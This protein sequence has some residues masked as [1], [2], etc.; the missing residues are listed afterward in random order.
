MSASSRSPL[1]LPPASRAAVEPLEEARRSPPRP[2]VPPVSPRQRVRIRPDER[3]AVVD[4]DEPVLARAARA[5]HEQRLDVG[6]SSREHRVRRLQLASTPRARAATRSRPSGSGSSATHA[7]GRGAAEEERHVDRDPQLVPG[8]VVELEAV[9]PQPAVGD[10]P[11]VAAAGRVAVEQQRCT[12]GR[13]TAARASPGRAGGGARRRSARCTGRSAP[14]TPTR[15][16]RGAARQAAEP[17]AGER[18]APV[19]RSGAPPASATF[20][21]PAV[22]DQQRDRVEV[23]VGSST[24]AAGA[25]HVVARARSRGSAARAPLSSRRLER[26]ARRPGSPA[27]RRRASPSSRTNSTGS[28]ATAFTSSAAVAQLAAAPPT[29]AQLAGRA[30]A[31]RRCER[32]TSWSRRRG[33]RRRRGA[34]PRPRSPRRRARPCG[35]RP[36][37][38]AS[39][40]SPRRGSRCSCPPS[41]GARRRP[42]SPSSST[43]PPWDS[44]YGR[45]SRAPRAPAPR[46]ARG[47]GRAAAAGATTSS[48]SSAASAPSCVAATC[49]HDPREPLAVEVEQRL[50][51]ARS[52]CRA[53]PGR[54]APRPPR[55]APRP[56]RPA[57]VPRCRPCRA[58]A[59][60]APNIGECTCFSVLPLP[61]YMCTPHGRHGSKLR[62]ARMMSMPRKSSWPFSSKIGWPITASS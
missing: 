61:R 30:A 16:R 13:R 11:V 24:H 54:R 44:R 10:Q 49:S 60:L 53:P 41:A 3:V 5:V 15:S 7:P 47:A 35:S 21:R 55:G 36:R 31:R 48:S 38:R 27:G 18:G 2:R 50:H 51:D 45:T 29:V 20:T 62:T 12:A 58:S 46:A 39:A 33:G 56:A 32:G 19:M 22:V 9:E 25:R 37:S 28:P 52:P 1:R 14:A 40:S 4:R 26:R 42:R 34:R 8:D 17:R 23:Q 59:V 57:R 43:S 6:L